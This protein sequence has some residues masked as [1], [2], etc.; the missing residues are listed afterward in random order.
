M[1]AVRA[2]IQDSFNIANIVNGAICK[3]DYFRKTGLDRID[4]TTIE[5]TIQYQPELHW[6]VLRD[7]EDTVATIL[8]EAIDAAKGSIQM[9]CTR[10]DKQ[11]MGLGA[12]LLEGVVINENAQKLSLWCAEVP[13]L[14]KYYEKLGFRQFNRK[15]YDP[16]YLKDEWKGKVSIVQMKRAQGSRLRDIARIQID[17]SHQTI[18]DHIFKE[19]LKEIKKNPTNHDLHITKAKLTESQTKTLIEFS[20]TNAYKGFKITT[21]EG[22]NLGSVHTNWTKYADEKR[23]AYEG[24]MYETT[25]MAL[26]H[27][28]EKNERNPEFILDFGAGT[29]RDTINLALAECPKILAV[30]GDDHSLTILEENLKI[31][32]ITAEVSCITSPFISLE[33]PEKAELLVSSHTLPYRCPK[34]FPACF[35]KCVESLKIGGYLAAHFF[36]PITGKEPDPGL[37][38]HSEEKLLELLKKNFEIVWFK[39]DP[40]G[41]PCQIYG[42]DNPPWGDLFHVVAKRVY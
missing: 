19:L 40:E 30:D 39:K 23:T 10:V 28:Q 31:K 41:T 16:A 6:Y 38:Y 11:S 1:N 27:F 8:Y 25:S 22:E 37:T 32:G 9:F 33:I 35:N 24:G 21:T 42:G 7:L 3:A 36:G 18:P 29:G 26:K 20:G 4:K 15:S 34:D 5:E 2:T 13:G 12:K 17:L 14:V